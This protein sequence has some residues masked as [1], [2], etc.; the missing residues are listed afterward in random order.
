MTTLT[1]NIYE[2]LMAAAGDPVQIEN[3]FHEFNSSKG[4]FYIALAKAT[5]SLKEHFKEISQKCADAD[6]SYQGKQQHIET[7][8]HDLSVINLAI[9]E[10][11]KEKSILDSR[12]DAKKNLLDEAKTI[13]GFG[14]GTKQLQ[15]LHELLSKMAASQGIKPTEAAV[16]FFNEIGNYQDLRYLSSWK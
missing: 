4:P 9:D 12:I 10:K 14:F 8:D 11:N 1:E 6:K 2:K 13:A 16:L 3:V 15:Q 5:A 7:A